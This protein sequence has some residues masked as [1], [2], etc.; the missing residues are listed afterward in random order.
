MS[1][2]EGQT[3]LLT[4]LIMFGIILSATTIGGYL[5]LN[6][7]RQAGN[8]ANSVKAIM[9][10]DTGIECEL[11]RMFK[12]DAVNCNTTGD[13]AVTFEESNVTLKTSRTSPM[14]GID[15][16]QSTGGSARTFRAFELTV[17]TAT[18]T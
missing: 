2:A 1:G 4:V 6:Q 15:V 17:T 14:P 5:M 3:M 11:Y 18:S 9:A 12:D 16:I 8:A 13:N 10:A 7:L